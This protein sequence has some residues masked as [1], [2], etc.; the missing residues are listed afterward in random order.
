VIGLFN[1]KQTRR[2]RIGSTVLVFAL[3]AVVLAVAGTPSEVSAVGE[4]RPGTRLLSPARSPLARL[5]PATLQ[6]PD[7]RPIGAIMLGTAAAGFPRNPRG[8]FL[9]RSVDITTPQGRKEFH[10]RLMQ[11]AD[12]SIANLRAMNAQG[13]ITWDIEGEQYPHPQ[14]YVGD[15]RLVDVLAPEMGACVD[16][17]FRRF[18][19]A[20]FRVG[21][22]IR[23]QQFVRS[24]DQTRASQ[25]ELV[26]PM[27]QLEDKLTYAETRWGAT[28]FYIDSNRVFLVADDVLRTLASRHPKALLIPEH[29]GILGYAVAAPYQ[30]FRT[31][32]LLSTRKVARVLYPDSF[33]V[34]DVADEISP[35]RISDLSHHMRSGDVILFR[36][37]FNDPANIEIRALMTQLQPKY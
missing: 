20:G 5:Y 4:R 7:R 22:T 15:P 37:W 24:A 11:L 29:S 1:R 3:A 17:Y 26:D 30:K 16:E 33:E 19:D 23:P 36:C 12:V 9:D 31:Q 28:L 21:I 35:A 32:P 18:R 6:W 14:T 13:A 2:E 25:E 10:D 34:L 8:W 27:R